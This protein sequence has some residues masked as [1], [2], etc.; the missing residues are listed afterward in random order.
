[1]WQLPMLMPDAPA[2]AAV[3][4]GFND[5]LSNSMFMNGVIN[6]KPS[7]QKFVPRFPEVTFTPDAMSGQGLR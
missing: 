2:V 6:E 1:M 7:Q 5:L 3:T 4:F